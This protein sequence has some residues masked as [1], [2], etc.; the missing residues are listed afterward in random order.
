[1]VNSPHIRSL[2]LHRYIRRINNTRKRQ[3]K[4]TLSSEKIAKQLL[5]EAGEKVKKKLIS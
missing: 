1:M 5:Q 4:T 3:K 2:S